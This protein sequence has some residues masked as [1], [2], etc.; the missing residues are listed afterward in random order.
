MQAPFLEEDLVVGF[1][2]FGVVGDLIVGDFVNF[3]GQVDAAQH[4]L[5][6]GIIG[7]LINEIEPLV[8]TDGCVDELLCF[9]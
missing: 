2:H 1:P 6:V 5:D 9:E 4:I 7:I 3:E 8:E